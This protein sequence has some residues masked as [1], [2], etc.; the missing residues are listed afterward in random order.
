[1][2]ILDRIKAYKLQE[3]AAAK[4]A[5]P[6]AEVEAAAR[7]ASAP[8]GFAR[9]LTEK[10]A[11]GHAL[12]AEIKKASPSKGLIRPDFDPPAL[13]RAYQAGGAACLSVLTDGPSFQGAPEFL[14]AARAACDLP[15][16]RKDFLYDTYQVAEARAWGAD[17]IL[18][19]MASLDDTLAAELEDAAFHWGMDALIE[20][21]DEAEMERALRLKSPLVGVNNRNLKTFEISIE[22]TLRLAPMVPQDRDLV[23]ESGLFTPEDLNRMGDAGIRRFLIGESLMRQ[24]DVTGATRNILGLAA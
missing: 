1:M 6:L 18:I 22:T 12:I 8:R 24:D 11:T 20:V 21:H 17:C 10:A 5:R 9:A 4:A 14:T 23:C 19:I 7:E 15:A 3:I 13:A 16:L 2:D